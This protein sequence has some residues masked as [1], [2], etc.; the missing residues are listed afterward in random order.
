M[1]QVHNHAVRLIGQIQI[2][3]LL[4]WSDVCSKHEPPLDGLKQ[5]E[6]YI[7]ALL[8]SMADT[9]AQNIDDG[10]WTEDELEKAVKLTDDTQRAMMAYQ[11]EKVLLSM[12][13]RL[14]GQQ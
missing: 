14:Y 3:L 1:A 2:R 11:A 8:K 7:D 4:L 13:R 6:E 12:Q 9:Y 10:T 5:K